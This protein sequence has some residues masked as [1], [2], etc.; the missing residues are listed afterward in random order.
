MPSTPRTPTSPASFSPFVQPAHPH[1]DAG[2]RAATAEGPIS[3]GRRARIEALLSEVEQRLPLRWAGSPLAQRLRQLTDGLGRFVPRDGLHA[4]HP[5]QDIQEVEAEVTAL[6]KGWKQ[7]TD[8]SEALS[9]HPVMD[10]LPHDASRLVTRTMNT[11]RTALH[12]GDLARATAMAEQF[13]ATIR[14]HRP[15]TAGPSQPRG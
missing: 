3:R 11:W 9:R 14:Q 8:A 7:W 5:Y 13:L 1:T 4:L 10:K 2:D 12:G 6:I 15:L